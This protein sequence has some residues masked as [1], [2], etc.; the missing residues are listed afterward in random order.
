LLGGV[1]LV[2][3][4]AAGGAAYWLTREPS[5]PSADEVSA[6]VKLDT[7]AVESLTCLDNF[8]YGISPVNISPWDGNTKNWLAILVEAGIYSGPQQVTSGGWIP[9]EHLQ[10]EHT[11]EGKKSIRGKKLCYA[12]GIAIES[13]KYAEPNLQAKPARVSGTAQYRLVK[14]ASWISSPSAKEAMPDRFAKNGGELQLSFVL[15]DGKWVS[16]DKAPQPSKER[17][18]PGGSA[19]KAESGGDLFSWFGNLFGGNPGSALQGRWVLS[20]GLVPMVFEFKPESAVIM[21]A[22]VPAT[23]SRS[24]D[25]V[26]LRASSALGNESMQFRIVSSEEV[27]LLDGSPNGAKLTRA[28]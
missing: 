14:P 23:Y 11:E 4:A 7:A 18:S 21:G 3:I 16:P 6:L 26:E 12:E 28:K 22:E 5:P 15:I 2:A 27:R 19:A 25:V 9:Q 17:R 13:V 8:N 20:Q 10:Y 24:G 1:A